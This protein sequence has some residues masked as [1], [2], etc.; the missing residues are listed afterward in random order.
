MV[1]VESQSSAASAIL[2][3]NA[4]VAGL[5]GFSGRESSVSAA[6]IATEI[7]SGRLRWIVVDSSQTQRLPGDTRRGSES[8]FAAVRRACRAVSISSGGARVT[9]Y[10]CLGRAGVIAS[11]RA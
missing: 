7:R 6:W 3:E 5:G 2:S 8:A 11:D 9:M 1:G 10:D 4:D